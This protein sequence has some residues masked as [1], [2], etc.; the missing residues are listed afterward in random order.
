VYQLL[1]SEATGQDD[2]S[3]Q[4]EAEFQAQSQT[5]DGQRVPALMPMA[6]SPVSLSRTILISPSMCMQRL[7]SSDSGTSIDF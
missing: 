3:R 5:G 4:S 2:C 6:T 7:R 1:G